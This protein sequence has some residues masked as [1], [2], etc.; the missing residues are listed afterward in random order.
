M[1]GLVR[2]IL[3]EIRREAVAIGNAAIKKG[4]ELLRD[5]LEGEATDEQIMAWLREVQGP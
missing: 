4:V 1:D 3:D 2:T 5:R